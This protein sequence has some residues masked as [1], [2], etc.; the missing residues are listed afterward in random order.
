MIPPSNGF[1]KLRGHLKEFHSIRVNN[2]WHI[3]FRW[4]N[5]KS[6]DFNRNA[7]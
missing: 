4:D 3:I 6:N 7:S 2:Q 5:R 1:I